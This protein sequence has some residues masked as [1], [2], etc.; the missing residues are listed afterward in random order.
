[1]ID[2]KKGSRKNMDNLVMQKSLTAKKLK[3]ANENI[4]ENSKMIS[5]LNSAKL[6]E[7]K[8][9]QNLTIEIVEKS[10]TIKNFENEI[11]NY[12]K[13]IVNVKNQIKFFKDNKVSAEIML[14]EVNKKDEPLKNEANKNMNELN[15]KSKELIAAKEKVNKNNCISS[16]SSSFSK[17]DGKFN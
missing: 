7:E 9:Y 13:D 1:M 10:N 2:N 8:S 11:K 15:Q 3:D 5:N 12:E 17:N 4:E 16:K 14:N 6:D